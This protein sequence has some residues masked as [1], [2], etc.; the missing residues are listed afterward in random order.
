MALIEINNKKSF[1]PPESVITFS[2]GSNSP[3]TITGASY[4]IEIDGNSSNDPDGTIISYQ[5]ERKVDTEEWLLQKTSTTPFFSGKIK[6]TGVYKYRLRCI[7]NEGLEGV[8]EELI[9]NFTSIASTN[10]TANIN[11]STSPLNDSTIVG[12]DYLLDAS[13]SLQGTLEDS[14]VS[15]SWIV[16]SAINTDYTITK[17][18]SNTASIKV[19][20]VNT[21][22]IELTVKNTGNLTDTNEITLSITQNYQ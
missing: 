22:V 1:L 16:L 10:P 4:D 14:I 11:G 6:I 17:S 9:V 3:K 20:S 12:A 5:W 13:A 21:I 18:S 7:D 19:N 8:S 15:Y 2:G